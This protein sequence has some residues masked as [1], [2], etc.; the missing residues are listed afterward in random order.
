[1]VSSGTL[2]WSNNNDYFQGDLDDFRVYPYALSATLAADLYVHPASRW[3]WR[4]TKHPASTSSPTVRATIVSV[5]CSGDAC[6]TSGVSGRKNQAL[7]F[8]GVDDY[9]TIGASSS[10]LGLSEGDFSVM[11]WIKPDTFRG[12]NDWGLVPLLDVGN[13][14]K[15]AAG[16][17]ASGGRR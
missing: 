3:T 17:W 11:M 4:S 2:V 6:P 14:Y 15:P 7:E 8:D 5:A 1:M 16:V 12:T 10:E 13:G 9:L